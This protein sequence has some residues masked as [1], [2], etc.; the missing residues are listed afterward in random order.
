MISDCFRRMFLIDELCDTLVNDVNQQSKDAD[1]L[2]NRD[3][4]GKW[5]GDPDVNN[6]YFLF[7]LCFLF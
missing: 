5:A 2:I 1:R 3:M 7:L 6:G 4:L